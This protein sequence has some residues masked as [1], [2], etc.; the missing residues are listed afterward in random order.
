MDSV[1]AFDV[2]AADLAGSGAVVGK[3]FGHP[4]LKLG[5]QVFASEFYGA[6]AFK[7]GRESSAHAE[8][9]MLPGAM[10]FDPGRRNRPLKDWVEVPSTSADQWSAL[11]MAALDHLVSSAR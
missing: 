10:P 9:L 4:A 6:M 1:S 7:L 8:A 2:V 3:L 11:A 5:R